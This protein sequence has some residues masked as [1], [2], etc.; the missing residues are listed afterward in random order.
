MLCSHQTKNT[1]MQNSVSIELNA[2][3]INWNKRVSSYAQGINKG[4]K[5][6]ATKSWIASDLQLYLIF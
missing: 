5:Y 3:S 2:F 4:L 6:S 1:E